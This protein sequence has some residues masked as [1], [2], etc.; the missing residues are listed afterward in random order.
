MLLPANY[1]EWKKCIVHKCGII[2]TREFIESRIAALRNID[3]PAITQ[4]IRLYG[5]EH[6]ANVISWF[7][8]AKEA[9]LV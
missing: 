1:G 6:H 7:I 4:F 8:T 9:L 3:D 5:L 2:L